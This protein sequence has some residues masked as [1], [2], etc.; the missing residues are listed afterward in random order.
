VPWF[1]FCVVSPGLIECGQASVDETPALLVCMRSS[2]AALSKKL[3]FAEP[4]IGFAALA[5]D[6]HR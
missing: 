1:V 5:I 2:A 3:G 6:F 4:I